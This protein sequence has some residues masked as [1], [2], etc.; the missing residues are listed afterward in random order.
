MSCNYGTFLDFE[1][2]SSYFVSYETIL[3]VLKNVNNFI[4][5]FRGELGIFCPPGWLSSLAPELVTVL[6]PH[7]NIDQMLPFT[8]ETD[9]YAF[10]VVCFELFS[11]RFLHEHVSCHSVIWSVAS[12]CKNSLASF[13]SSKRFKVNRQLMCI[14]KQVRLRCNCRFES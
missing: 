3:F 4:F 10:G 5:F 9:V 14:N 1:I 11:G 12:G 13:Q 6:S 8:M 2:R 7:W